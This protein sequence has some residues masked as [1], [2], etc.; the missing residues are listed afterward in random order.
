MVELAVEEPH[1]AD[2]GRTATVEDDPTGMGIAKDCS[3]LVD[4]FTIELVGWPWTVDVAQAGC[5]SVTSLQSGPLR[6]GAQVEY[7]GIARFSKTSPVLNLGLGS[8]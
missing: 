6:V 3:Q 7:R 2:P 8:E 5:F 4:M 1:Q